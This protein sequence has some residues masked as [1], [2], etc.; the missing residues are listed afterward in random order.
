MKLLK[1]IF[2]FI[3]LAAMLDSCKKDNLGDCFTGTGFVVKETR[4]L[5]AFD[6][7]FVNRRL[8][9]VLIEDSVNYVVVEAGENL[10]ENIKTEVVNGL[11]TIENT[12][13]CNWVRSYKIPVKIEIHFAQL[14]Y[15]KMFGSSIVSSPDTLH[16]PFLKFEFI[17]SSGDLDL[18][19]DNEEISII[20][21]TGSNDVIV[22]GITKHLSV[23]MSSMGSGDYD[24]LFAET[25][26]VQTLSSA[27]CRVFGTESFFFRVNGDGGIFYKGDGEVIFYERT[28]SGSIAPIL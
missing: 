14:R 2:A 25:V 23:Y 9:V 22:K 27:N 28:G 1:T 5:E 6:S 21:N 26:Y 4:E 10:Q 18:L 11:L 7:I 17:D 20:Q 24:E 13:T 19:V 12:N 8:E 15:V 16:Q 3:C